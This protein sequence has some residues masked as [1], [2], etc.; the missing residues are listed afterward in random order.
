MAVIR[1]NKSKNFTTMSN[2]HF[3]DMNLSLKAKGLLS[4]MF[5]LPDNWDYS[6]EGLT[7]ICKESI[8]AINSTLAELKKYG[9][10]VIEKKF[11]NET[12]SGRIEYIYQ[13]YETPQGIEKQGIEKQGIEKQGIE[14]Q[15]VEILGIENRIQYNTNKQITNNQLTNKQITNNICAKKKFT[16]PTYEEVLAY[17]EQRK[18][19]DLARKFFDYYTVGNWID[20]KGLNVKNWKQKFITWENNNKQETQTVKKPLSKKDQEYLDSIDYLE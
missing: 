18:R 13:I 5:S 2:F 17:A 19:T 4:Q 7:K 20:G 16:P 14:K 12:K 8:S 10:L 6:A 3:R 15:G 1:V 11:P 9:Y